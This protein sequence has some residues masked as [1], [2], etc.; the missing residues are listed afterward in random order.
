MKN[1]NNT[2]CGFVGIVGRPNVGKSTLL[3][4]ILG[5]KLSITSSKP[6][7]TRHRLLGIA[8]EENT[9]VVYVDT[10]GLHQKAKNTL[11][12]YLNQAAL[13]ALRDLNLV[14]WVIDCQQFTADDEWVASHLKKIDIPVILVLNKIDKLKQRSDLLPLLQHYQEKTGISEMIPVCALNGEQIPT[15]KKNIV[16]Y[17]PDSPFFFAENQISD[18]NDAFLITEI[19]REKLMRSLEK[20]LP[21]A[22]TVTI[23]ALAEEKDLLRVATI[24]WVEKESHKPIVIGRQGDHLKKI[25]KLA[26]KHIEDHFGKQCY[27]QLWVKVKSGWTDNKK[28]LQQFGYGP[29]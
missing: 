11:N 22:L 10:P 14:L 4:H 16:N 27:L 6:Q 28:A 1:I 5:F 3:N 24:I 21:Y 20:E 25:G 19:I 9:Q 15:L 26:R 13:R 23:E 29:S 18:R 7:T 8:T 17:L 12:R 2:R